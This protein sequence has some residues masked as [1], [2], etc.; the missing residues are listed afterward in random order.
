MASRLAGC[1][2]WGSVLLGLLL[3]LLLLGGRPRARKMLCLVRWKDTDTAAQL[4]GKLC[5]TYTYILNVVERK[6]V[7]AALTAVIGC[8]P[9][10]RRTLPR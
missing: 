6:K 7:K 3:L 5:Y 1:R 8:P 10:T 4:G 9:D 2:C